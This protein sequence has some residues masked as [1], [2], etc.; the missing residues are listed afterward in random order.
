MTNLSG[1][2]VI[3]ASAVI[4]IYVREEQSEEM[5]RLIEASFAQRIPILVPDLIFAECANILWKKVRR[6]EHSRDKVLADIED[7][8]VLGVV[9][10]PTRD[11]AER[12]LE[13]ACDHGIAAYDACYVAL[14]EQEH[15]PLL[16]AD[17]R[18]ASSLSGSAFDLMVLGK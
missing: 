17:T 13:I 4:K 15:V 2:Y 8:R 1:G 9:S 5:D 3:D 7:L 16:T 6:G 18:L 10:V 12:A 11:L 14:S